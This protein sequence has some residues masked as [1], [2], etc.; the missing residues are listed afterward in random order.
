MMMPDMQSAYKKQRI[1]SKMRENL[2]HIP[3]FDYY[4]FIRIAHL[5]V[6][7]NGIF[8]SYKKFDSF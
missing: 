5:F 7:F 3:V 4:S 2:Y 6:K 1:T 8:A